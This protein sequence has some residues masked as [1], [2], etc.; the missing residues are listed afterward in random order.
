MLASSLAAG[1]GELID[2]SL[3]TYDS[4]LFTRDSVV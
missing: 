3:V 2:S 4:S 1:G